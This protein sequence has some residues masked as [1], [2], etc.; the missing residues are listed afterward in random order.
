ML[1]PGGSLLP[2]V[3]KAKKK[4]KKK[5]KDSALAEGKEQESLKPEKPSDDVRKASCLLLL[6]LIFVSGTE[7]KSVKKALTQQSYEIH[8]KSYRVNCFPAHTQPILSPPTTKIY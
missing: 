7:F 2:G 1:Q 3:D 5:K 4:K 6:S 8:R